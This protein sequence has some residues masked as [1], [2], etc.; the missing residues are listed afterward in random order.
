MRLHQLDLENFRGVRKR[1]ISF[2]EN[3][4]TVVV[5]DNE[6]GKS[7]ILEAF[8]LLIR[9]HAESTKNQLKS[10]KPVGQDVGVEV[11]AEF[12]LGAGSDTLRLDYRKRWLRDRLTELTITGADGR[13]TSLVGREAHD[14]ASTLFG[15]HVD[16][17][18]WRAL[19]VAQTETD[20]VPEANE[21]APL[22]TAL[23]QQTGED[24]APG[25]SPLLERIDREYHRYF[26]PANRNPSGEYARALTALEESRAAVQRLEEREAEVTQ[27]VRRAERLSEDLERLRTQA[28][29]LEAEVTRWTKEQTDASERLNQREQLRRE[30][31][32][33]SERL[34][35][36]RAEHRRRAM[37]RAEVDQLTSALAEAQRELG[38]AD[39]QLRRAE[40]RLTERG[41]V[42]TAARQKRAGARERAARLEAELSDHRHRAELAD[43]LERISEIEKAR[44]A[45]LAAAAAVQSHPIDAAAAERAEEAHR[46]VLAARAA[47]RAGAPTIW[48]HVLGSTPVSVDGVRVEAGDKAE[49]HEFVV[50]SE[51][52]VLADGVLEL[53]AR[54]GDDTQ[55]LRAGLEAAEHAEREVLA[56]LGM[57]DLASVRAG[58]HARTEAEQDLELARRTLAVRLAGAD[59]AELTARADTLRARLDAV[60]DARDDD[61][62][63]AEGRD[64]EPTPGDEEALRS[65]LDRARTTESEAVAALIAAEEDE[66]AIRKEV[67]SARELATG[68]RVRVEQLR[69][70]Q[71]AAERSLSEARSEQPDERLDEE[72][73]TVTEHADSVL[74]KHQEVADAVEAA[75]DDR[76][77]DELARAIELRD[78]AARRIESYQG[79]LRQIEGRLEM[80][81]AQ[82]I[83]SELERA[84][85]TEAAAERTAQLLSRR[86]EAA[87]LL[88]ETIQRHRAAAHRRYAAPLRQRID[89]LG[90]RAF[91]P[92]FGVLLDEDLSVA[93]RSLHNVQVPVSALSTGAREQLGTI[94]RLAIAELAGAS[95]EGVPVV[96]DD[97][98]SWSDQGRLRAMGALLER[99]GENGQVLL[100][101]CTADRYSLIRHDKLVLL[102]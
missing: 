98:L 45:E 19:V 66:L 74:A 94:V 70:Q 82:G 83:A 17:T 102:D 52:T 31:E 69:E 96:L 6:T 33:A 48:L 42:L 93:G 18:L 63:T 57:P 21:V 23:E 61:S 24:H 16:E 86:A 50:Q 26:T 14:H 11:R 56:E 36:A 78:A 29:E 25:T 39:E 85:A 27:D 3:G 28:A 12:S 49:K 84:R 68:C 38:K 72:L 60:G 75:G 5:G 32:L 67:E 80:A 64:V 88:A 97:A 71:E 99:A 4:V 10:V 54:P 47:A 1:S 58:L 92:S 9:V 37:R 43:L 30:A 91:G 79:D 65:D 77:E 101:T 20:L 55:Q 87:K 15:E 8:D 2:A 13:V 53:S 73:A 46:Q 81:G 51:T 7:S 100:L 59:L 44:A 35:H 41:A 34:N 40:S 76:I 22:L 62:I 90:R 95:G 89:E